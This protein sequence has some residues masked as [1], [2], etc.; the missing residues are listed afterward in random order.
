M[1]L[2]FN[3]WVISLLCTV[4]I[5]IFWKRLFLWECSLPFFV[6]RD[7]LWEGREKTQ[8]TV[9][10]LQYCT[11]MKQCHDTSR[12]AFCTRI[13]CS[14]EIQIMKNDRRLY[15]EK[16]LL[17]YK[18]LPQIFWKNFTPFI[19]FL[20]VP[21]WFANDITFAHLACIFNSSWYSL[22]HHFPYLH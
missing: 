6:L 17:N 10:S 12:T 16:L 1:S 21:V 19:V 8:A 13:Y 15:R 7:F 4:G 3:C 22:K 9:P 14:T 11:Q 2:M 18:I 5:L 20:R